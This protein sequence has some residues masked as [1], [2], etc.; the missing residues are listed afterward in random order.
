MRSPRPDLSAATW[1]TSSYSNSDGGN[2]VEI[3]DDY[4][5]VVPVRD[6]KRRS[7]PVLM[8]SPTAFAGLVTLAK[9][10]SA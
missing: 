7:G 5:G 8:L 6:S 2:C 4:T 1:R 3:S 9:R 10:A